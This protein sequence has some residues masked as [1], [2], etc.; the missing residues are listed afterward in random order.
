[1]KK[2]AALTSSV[3][4][5]CSAA[6]C[7]RTSSTCA[8]SAR[9]A[10]IP[11]ASPSR[12]S[13]AT[14]SSTR[15]LSRPTITT[16]PPSA[17]T[18]AA[19]ALPIPLLPPTA[20]SLRPSKQPAITTSSLQHTRESA[21]TQDHVPDPPRP[22]ESGLHLPSGNPTPPSYA[23]TPRPRHGGS[24][25]GGCTCALSLWALGAVPEVAE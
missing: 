5:P 16:L 15:S 12:P 24:P 17:T 14:V 11:T 9:S 10:V 7:C 1:M 21:T 23:P 6:S 18:S 2:P 25:L 3:A 4:S 8:R 22:K 20:I 13:S 19:F